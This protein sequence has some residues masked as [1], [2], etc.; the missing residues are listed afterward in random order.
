M[1]DSDDIKILQEENK[2]LKTENELLKKQNKCFS[3]DR[4]LIY[5]TLN[6][7]IDEYVDNMDPSQKMIYYMPNSIEK[8]IYKNTCGIMLNFMENMMKD[9][10][11]LSNYRDDNTK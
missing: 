7:T 10:N 11:K 4:E 6:K 5:N 3:S 1:K 8:K 9:I 2:K